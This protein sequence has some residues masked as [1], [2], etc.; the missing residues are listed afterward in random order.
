M[1]NF[2]PFSYMPYPEYAQK[3]LWMGDAQ[4]DVEANVMS[5]SDFV[6]GHNKFDPDDQH[7]QQG[8]SLV[9]S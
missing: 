2:K 1:P 7:D 6:N 9:S 8:L 4:T 3:P 5:P